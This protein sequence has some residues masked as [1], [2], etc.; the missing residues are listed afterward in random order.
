MAKPENES[1]REQV[2]GYIDSVFSE[3][4][5]EQLAK[6]YRRWDSVFKHSPQLSED[7]GEVYNDLFARDLPTSNPQGGEDPLETYIVD[8]DTVDVVGAPGDDEDLLDDILDE[9]DVDPEPTTL[10]LNRVLNR[11]RASG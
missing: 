5:D 11:V 7:P 6:T 3:S 1:Y 2:C 8:T 4:C 10:L 9:V